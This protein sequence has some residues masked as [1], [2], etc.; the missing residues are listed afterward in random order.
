M[1]LKEEMRAGDESQ[2]VRYTR[3][4]IILILIS[5]RCTATVL[6]EG[7]VQTFRGAGSRDWS[8][9]QREETNIIFG[10]ET[11]GQPLDEDYQNH[12]ENE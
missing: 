3:R 6:L 9:C 10:Q 2:M 7:S 4:Y 12:F 5:G 11:P 1:I 8:R